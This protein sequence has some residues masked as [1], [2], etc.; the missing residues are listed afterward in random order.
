MRYILLPVGEAQDGKLH[1]GRFTGEQV[2][3][4][5]YTPVKHARSTLMNFLQ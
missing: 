3:L 5:M 2:R 4:I 1:L